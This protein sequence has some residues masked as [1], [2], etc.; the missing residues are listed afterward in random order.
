MAPS[1]RLRAALAAID[2]ANAADPTMVTV[3]GSR[4]PKEI[5]H[6]N[7]VTEWVLRLRPDADEALLLAARG[8]HFR[9]WTVPRPSY[10]AGRAGYLKWRK[11]L[12]GQHA[13]ELGALLTE[14][15][16]DDATIA[17]V[18][19]IV[20]KDGLA[21]AAETDDVQVLEDALC[22][23]FLETQLV[24][25]AARLD[26]AKLPGVITKT[27]HKMSAAGLAAI[28][29]VPLGPGTHR[30]LDEAFA[31]DVVQRYLTAMA[32]GAW[33]E[34]AATLAPDVERIGPYGD[35]FSGRE[36]YAEFLE[37]IIGSLSGYELV[38][39]DMIVDGG[40][41]A[42]ELH[43][44]VDDGDARLRTDETVVFDVR[45]GV[46]VKVAVYL[47]KSARLVAGRAGTAPGEGST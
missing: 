8:H 10:P 9:R 30:I 7:L 39:A 2:D 24:D 25:I 35:N 37:Q 29:E 43:E 47:Q 16:Y 23:V 5:I 42:V 21:R 19:A 44:T 36:P 27:A 12:H 40:R 26:P 41:V 6:A 18:Q 15:G 33:P 32:T 46:I 1:P 34:L 22:L 11:D 13:L 45:N 20:R 3:R 28:A 4:G 38:V 31:R 14:A 17:R